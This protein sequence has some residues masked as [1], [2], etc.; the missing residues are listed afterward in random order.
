MTVKAR[1]E[2]AA[3]PP[4]LPL[5]PLVAPNLDLAAP[6]VCNARSKWE[7]AMRTF[8]MAAA[9]LGLAAC[10]TASGGAPSAGNS[11]PASVSQL[12]SGVDVPYE[13]FTLD[14]GLTV[15]V[16]ED[17]K[18]PIVAIAA[19]YNVGSKDEPAGRTGFAHLFEHIM[20]FN[21]TEHVP[22]LI[23][24][25]RDMGATNW[26]GTTWFDRTNYFQTVPTPALE[27]GLYIESERM[28]YILGAL[29]Q[30]RLDAQRGI[31]QNEKRE[32][33]NQPYGLT[34]YR[35]LEGLFP[36]GHPYRHSTIGSMADLDQ[37]SLE[38]VRQWFR[39]NYGPNNA[40][41]VLTGD[42][43][44]AEARPLMERYFGQIARGRQNVPAAAD[45]PTLAAPMSET[46][47]D[48]VSNSR[49]YR[50]WAV[51]GLGH[52]DQQ[53]LNTA[54]QVLGG[55]ATSRLDRELVRGDQTAVSVGAFMLPFQRLSFFY[56]TVDVKPGEDVQ[57]VSNRLD[58]VIA[59]FIQTGPTEDEIQRV[60]TGQVT[61]G[62]FAIEQIGGF[63][64]QTVALANGAVL[65]GDPGFFRRNLLAYG[66]VTPASVRAVMNRWLTRPVYAL[67][68]DPGVREPYAEA[69]ATN[70]P[71]PD[72]R[73]PTVT[74]RD[75]M[76]PVGE[77]ADLDFPDVQRTTLS[78]GIEVVYA[79]RDA[80][81][82]TLV[83]IDF[84]AGIA[85]DPQGAFGVQVLTMA[86][87]SDGADGMDAMQIAEQQERLGASI[88]AGGTLDRS[89]VTLTA[90]SANLALSLDLMADIVQRPDF[91]ESEV[92]R[93][94]EQQ[95]AAVAAEA[96]QPNGLA[97][98][99]LPPLIYGASHPYGRPLSG[100]GS[101]A[102][103]SSLDRD[104]LIAFHQTWIRPETARIFVVSDRPLAEVRRLLDARFGNWRGANVPV[105]RKD[106]SAAIPT[107]QSRIVIID[108]PQSPQ[109]II[110]AGAV[111]PISGADNTVTLNAGNEVLGNNFLS[112]INTEIR[113][114]RGWSYGLSGTVQLREGRVP[115]VINAPVQSNRTGDSVRVLLEQINSF[116]AD[117]GVTEA[118][119]VRVINGNIRQLPGL[120]ETAA[121]ILGALRSNDLYDR[122]DDYWET[123]A[124]RYRV[125]TADQMDAAVREVVD[126]SRF[127]WVIVGDASVVRPQLEGI[128]LPIEVVQPN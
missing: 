82:A 79:Q 49:L 53:N 37:A 105:G 32:G 15:L 48:R 10:A 62:L 71:A 94:R 14:N 102:S 88:V 122:P 123:L 27:R 83:A 31:V 35:I 21:G 73:P 43:N 59:N 80:I 8:V 29:T 66:D 58:G 45:V 116:R 112:R 106:F 41:I 1:R 20:L 90:L 34:F 42:I 77:I 120:Y 25:L 52:E 68:V 76:P 117:N 108:R 22:N 33:D 87:I 19:W 85:A 16:H 5:P 57:A 119:H 64:G 107:P 100:L 4:A 12:M 47:T 13:S 84:D 3:A 7:R 98:R 24:P 63:S 46:M 65:A 93:Q 121:S 75:P 101:T 39:D 124:G 54:A 97:Q 127:V 92:S 61:Q 2:Q 69:T 28:G 74:P 113:E 50:V 96:T 72:N 126:P 17:R 89:S 55:L 78:N 60:A 23:E 11:Q 118:E 110:Y 67:R 109:S 114:R 26:N 18:A 36:E 30:E 40:V 86:S 9:A 128:G 104:D 6:T 81:P 56:V 125:M 38:D 70:R 115:Y 51:P 95:L 111:L 103:V 99:A 44:A 91:A